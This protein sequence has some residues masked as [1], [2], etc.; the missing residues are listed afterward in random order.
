MVS[1]ACQTDTR[2]APAARVAHGPAPRPLIGAAPQTSHGVEWRRLRHE[3]RAAVQEQDFVLMYLPRRAL[4]DGRV[5]GA[6]AQ[7]RWPRRGGGLTPSASFMPLLHEMHLAAAVASWSLQSACLAASGWPD[8]Q[9]SVGVPHSVLVDGSLAEIVASAL[10]ASGLAPERLEIELAEPA[11]APALEHDHSE[12]LLTLSALRDLGV[13]ITLDGFGSVSASLL[14]VKILPLTALSLDRSLV[15]D[16]PEDRDAAAVVL[17]ATRFA[18]A[19]EVTVVGCG[20]E[21]QAQRDFLRRAGCARAQG[22]FIGKPLTQAAMP[23]VMTS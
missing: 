10:D 5:V 17:A 18:Q 9:V 16:L 3:L 2:D 4:A 15:R 1:N 14:T 20:V 12:T 8:G 22:A 19:L 11:L 13:G 7:L 23:A 6:Q 21:T